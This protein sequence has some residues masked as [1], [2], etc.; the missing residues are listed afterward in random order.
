MKH[1]LI[2]G[3]ALGLVSS[4][5]AAQT[6]LGN[7]FGGNISADTGNSNNALRAL[8][9]EKRLVER[10]DS[11]GLSVQGNY[12]SAYLSATA[13]Y[14]ALS[15]RYSEESQPSRDSLIGSSTIRL[16]KS[17]D[18]FSLEMQHSR[19]SLLSSPE[20]VNL[21]SDLEDREIISFLPRLQTKLGKVDQFYIQ[22]QIDSV[23]YQASELLNSTRQM[24]EI[25]DIHYLSEVDSVGGS[26]KNSS[27]DFDFIESAAYDVTIWNLYYHASLRQLDYQL[28][29]GESQTELA[30]GKTIKSP[31][32][33]FEAN[34]RSGKNQWSLN[35]ERSITDTSFGNGN[36]SPL[37]PDENSSDAMV[38]GAEQLDRKS[39]SLNL[40]IGNLCE[41]CA[42]GVGTLVSQDTQLLDDV[43]TSRYGW[44]SSFDYQ[45][46]RRGTL[47]ISY[48]T[49]I[50]K[51]ELNDG[52]RFNTETIGFEY[53][54]QFL[55]GIGLSVVT[56]R[57][58]RKDTTV[59]L[60][61][62]ER[63]SGLSIKYSF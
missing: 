45:L 11:F 55:S 34:Y 2:F 12:E 56:W 17:Q 62:V 58:K 8:D 4:A 43:E 10:Q 53:R 26:I 28:T 35:I 5:A 44:Q 59:N 31:T 42:L 63:Y 61:Y 29:L 60:G 19:S 3:V 24:V 21:S 50:Q 33:S 48:N 51:Y 46:S 37:E 20:L 15:E 41:R 27:I 14:S 40:D 7:S 6:N 9:G 16:G 23:N 49:S 36:S 38:S 13:N 30:D 57:E 54:Y 39:A 22:G 25:G 52:S 1:N 18:F 47:G 32:Y